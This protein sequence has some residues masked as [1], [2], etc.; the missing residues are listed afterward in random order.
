MI[1]L[2]D[3]LMLV[4]AL[5]VMALPVV[6]IVVAILHATKQFQDVRWIREARRNQPGRA[7][8]SE[9][10]NESGKPP[11]HRRRDH[12]PLGLLTQP[13]VAA[14]LVSPD[15]SVVLLSRIPDPW[16]PS[17]ELDRQACA[18]YANLL[19]T[20]A[21]SATWVIEL[22]ISTSAIL[23]SVF[24]AKVVDSWATNQAVEIVMMYLTMAAVV[25]IGTGSAVL[26]RVVP[27]WRSGADQYRKLADCGGAMNRTLASLAA[28]GS[29]DPTGA[30]PC[31]EA[32]ANAPAVPRTANPRAPRFRR[33]AWEWRSR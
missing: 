16:Q 7:A 25:L 24:A 10:G 32:S 26:L 13:E 5:I 23:G 14:L 2:I 21:I 12:E 9:Q 8:G 33:S 15:Q 11:R 1:D 28:S 3:V 18:V 31:S 6:L 29:P 22:T 17:L 4:V 30:G 19:R 20:R 27:Q